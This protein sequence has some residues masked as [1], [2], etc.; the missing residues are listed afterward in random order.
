MEVTVEGYGVVKDPVFYVGDIPIFYLPKAYFPVKGRDKQDFLSHQRVI[1][2]NTG[3]RC[4][5]PSIGPLTKT[6]MRPFMR[7]TWETE[8]SK[9]LSEY[10]YAL[11]K[12]TKGESKFYFINDQDTMTNGMPFL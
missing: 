4:K 3:W 6:W 12:E 1:R 5:R 7:A 9:K 11:T 2:T 8:S 10:R